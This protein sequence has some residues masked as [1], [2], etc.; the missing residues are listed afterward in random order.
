VNTIVFVDIIII[1]IISDDVLE[2]TSN[3]FIFQS[4]IRDSG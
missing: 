1:I 4:G 3:Y 2:N